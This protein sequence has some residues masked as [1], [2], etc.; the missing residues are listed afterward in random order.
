MVVVRF[1]RSFSYFLFVLYPFVASKRSFCRLDG[2]VLVPLILVFS[3][4][5]T[6]DISLSL[7]SI[8]CIYQL[9]VTVA[10]CTAYDR[11]TDPNDECNGNAMI[12]GL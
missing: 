7:L 10:Y 11:V 8:I 3:W 4:N 9:K 1:D 6:E 5:W 12:E 2:N